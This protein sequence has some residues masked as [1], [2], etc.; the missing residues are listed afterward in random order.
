MPVGYVMAGASIL[1]GLANANAAQNAAD[2]QAGASRYAADIQNQMFNKQNQ[3]LAPNRA[4][5][6]QALN[7]LGS[8]G[9]G[10][11]GMYDANGNPTGT[12]T[13]SGYLQ[14]Q[15]NAQDLQAGL[16]PN[17]DFMLQQG[18]MANQRAANAAGGAIGGNALQGLNQ[19]T[20]DYAG[21]AYQNAFNNFQTQRTGI[22]N[23]LAGIAGLGQQAQNTT[24]NLASNTAGSLGQTAI[25]GAAAQAAGTIGAAN[26]I[27]GGLQGAGNAYFLNNLMNRNQ[28]GYTPYS[29]PTT[30]DSSMNYGLQPTQPLNNFGANNLMQED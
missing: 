24:A 5:G 20:Q 9:S 1:G 10:T 23:T 6:Y 27:S 29:T 16:A 11:Y 13:G 26:S 22:Y 7:T 12:G 3:Q 21:N 2:T 28:S 30:P 18:Q 19:F 14:H 25:G 4:A 17:Y 8:M 15:F